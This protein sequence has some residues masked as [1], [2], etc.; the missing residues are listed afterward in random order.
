MK[1]R[2][3]SRTEVCHRTNS[4]VSAL[5]GRIDAALEL[6]GSL[7]GVVQIQPNLVLPLLRTAGQVL[8]VEGVSML[9]IKAIGA[10][11]SHGDSSACVLLEI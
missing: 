11:Y 4:D 5:T 8:T 7:L 9:H 3:V 6:L 10:D 2:E 1:M